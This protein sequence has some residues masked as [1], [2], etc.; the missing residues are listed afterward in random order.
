MLCICWDSDLRFI[1]LDI[2][3]MRAVIMFH[4]MLNSAGVPLF[5]WTETLSCEGISVYLKDL[6]F[7]QL[8]SIHVFHPL[9]LLKDTFRRSKCLLPQAAMQFVCFALSKLSLLSEWVQTASLLQWY[10]V[11][12]SVQI[13]S[14]KA[15]FL[16]NYLKCSGLLRFICKR[17]K[18]QTW[19]Q[20]QW[21]LW[22]E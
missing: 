16:Y 1:H 2:T 7:V 8:F 13:D 20:F 17:S 9:L 14:V 22:S 12:N 19:L 11:G 18:H 15:V 6:T 3:H 21:E 10:T 4:Y 5:P